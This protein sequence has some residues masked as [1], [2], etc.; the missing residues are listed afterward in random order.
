LA[1]LTK[2]SGYQPPTIDLDGV[3][4]RNNTATV[5]ITSVA[6]LITPTV[7]GGG[8]FFGVDTVFTVTASTVQSNAIRYTGTS[9]TNTNGLGG[10]LGTLDHTNGLIS[11]TEILSNTA[12]NF[13]FIGGA[14]MQTKGNQSRVINSRAS[15]NY[16]VSS[17]ATDFGGVFGGGYY[18]ADSG[19]AHI[20]GSRFEHNVI[21]RTS[22]NSFTSGGGV[23]VDGNAFITHTVVQSNTATQGGGMGIGGGGVVVARWVTVTYNVARHH[24]FAEGGGVGGAGN[25]EMRD[26]LIAH[27]VVTAP[28]YAAGGGISRYDG[29][30]RLTNV[31][32]RH[33]EVQAQSTAMG[34]GGSFGS[35]SQAHLTQTKVL[36]NVARSAGAEGYNGG[37]N[38]LGT[39]R[40]VTS[41]I[42]YNRAVGNSSSSSGGLGNKGTA[43]VIDSRIEDNLVTDLDGNVTGSAG[44]ISNG[45]SGTLTVRRS[46]IVGNQASTAAAIDTYEDDGNHP[47]TRIVN[48][49]VS[50]NSST[51]GGSNVI[52]T[53]TAYLT[54]TTIASNTGGGLAY[55]GVNVNAYGVLIAYNSYDCTSWVNNAVLN[56]TDSLSSGGGC[57][58]G[59]ITNADP[60]LE[61]LASNGG[62]TPNHALKPGSPALEGVA[63][64]GAD[65]DQ[66]GVSRPQ[67]QACDIGAF[68]MNATNLAVSKSVTPANPQTGDVLTYTIFVTN[69]SSVNAELVV[70]TDTL[71]GGRTSAACSAPAGSPW[72]AARPAKRCSPTPS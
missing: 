54:H 4:F 55:L 8:A 59:F 50:G 10:G 27:N 13:R 47:T 31:E 1:F 2:P 57:P 19:A 49:T 60:L 68:E 5:S 71:S 11:D 28:N 7:F 35:S 3:T 40:V 65:E 17:P 38:N 72:R 18:V 36:S 56:A 39:L 23:G 15:G 46:S 34:G 22:N 52:L 66:R 30:L 44:G 26:S 53:G 48:S 67:G 20:T 45:G 29:T 64:C 70:L 32:I 41:T 16:G 63:A 51:G 12:E 14:G 37:L 62:A 25:V 61:P 58:S 9:V 43:E 42:A 21:T 69:L 33:N 24:D 6:G